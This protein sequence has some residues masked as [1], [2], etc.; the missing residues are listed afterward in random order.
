M[1]TRKAIQIAIDPVADVD[2]R[3]IVLCDDGT[4]WRLS[5]SGYWVKAPAIPQDH[6]ARVT[7]SVR[8]LVP[9]AEGDNVHSY[10]LHQVPLSRPCIKCAQRLRYVE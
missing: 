9:R 8:M 4:L 10:C 5:R 1:T 6:E 7:H 3:T 2:G